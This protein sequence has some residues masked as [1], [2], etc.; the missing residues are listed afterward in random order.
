MTGA[1]HTHTHTCICMP[2]TGIMQN[3]RCFLK[4]VKDVNKCLVRKYEEKRPV[5]S[6]AAGYVHTTSILPYKDAV[7]RLQD[8]TPVGERQTFVKSGKNFMKFAR[9]VTVSFSIRNV[10]HD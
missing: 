9:C 8:C 1:K 4:Q 7:N 10:F 2:F 6:H 3:L 5:C